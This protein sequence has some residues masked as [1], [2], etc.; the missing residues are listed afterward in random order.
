MTAA[1]RLIVSDTSPLITLALAE[2]LD[3]LLQPGVPI[4]IPD[5]VYV[6]ATRIRSAAGASV[7]VD[8][9]NTHR[10]RAQIAPTEVGIDQIRR[11]E[12]GR[13]IRGL[14]EAAAIET[15]DRFLDADLDAR[16]LLLFE[17]SDVLRRRAVVDERIG[18]LSTGDFLRALEEAGL[19][20]SSDQIL[21]VA[22]A[23]GRNVDRQ[24]QVTS[25]AG[26]IHRLR[27]HLAKQSA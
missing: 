13:S 18:L 24:H 25:D 6:E 2:S 26:A 27:E 23:A 4:S 20:Q 14:G 7:I 1:L 19:I 12:E 8:W 5:A 17:D 10:V 22:S 16:A 21:N 3:L 11:L 9:L 15:L